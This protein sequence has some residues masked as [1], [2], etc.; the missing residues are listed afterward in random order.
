MAEEP[1]EEPEEPE[2]PEKPTEEPEAPAEELASAPIATPAPKT[3]KKAGLLFQTRRPA[4]GAPRQR[5]WKIHWLRSNLSW[6]HCA[7][8]SS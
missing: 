6:T 1:T 3:P 4:K 8:R 5:C 2:E 7:C